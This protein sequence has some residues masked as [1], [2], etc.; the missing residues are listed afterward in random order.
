MMLSNQS[1]SMRPPVS[2]GQRA[3]SR[4]C[5]DC[6]RLLA[7][8]IERLPALTETTGQ[9]AAVGAN[10]APQRGKAVAVEDDATRPAASPL[11]RLLR[12]RPNLV[13][14]GTARHTWLRPARLAVPPGWGRRGL[15]KDAKRMRESPDRAA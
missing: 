13:V 5:A 11:A 9:H 2:C 15:A 10:Q 8:L 14:P 1:G 4:R 7:G 6:G 12:A 3:A